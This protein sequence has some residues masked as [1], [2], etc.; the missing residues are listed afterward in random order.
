MTISPPSAVPS[1]TEPVAKPP[2][3][4]AGVLRRAVVTT[5]LFGSL[6]P[7]FVVVV[8]CYRV[9]RPNLHTPR[10]L[11]MDFDNV[12]LT[13]SDGLT[14]RAWWIPAKITT[15]RPTSTSTMLVCHGVGANR[16]DLLRYYSFLHD[17]GYNILSWDW[18]GHGDSDWAKVTFGL[19]EK[20]DVRA[21]LDWL[22]SHKP[23]PSKWIGA[24]AISM[25]AGIMLQSTAVCPEIQALVLDSPFASVRTMLPHKFVFL[26][27]WARGPASSV[28]SFYG[29]LIMGTSVDAVAPIDHVAAFAPRPIFVVHGTADRVI[30]YQ[31]SELLEAAALEPKTV[32]IVPGGEHVSVLHSHS[33]EFESRVLGFLAK[34]VSRTVAPPV[35]ARD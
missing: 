8:N 11:G 24:L 4:I 14:L 23:G 22:A 32:W 33:Q 6:L 3:V 30:P 9:R 16:D 17:G 26:P 7:L 25:G 12:A 21:A 5:A 20:R 1:E 29:A 15:E 19:E 31:Q 34:A 18:R 35:A 10:T 27:E 28:A 2:S 13:T